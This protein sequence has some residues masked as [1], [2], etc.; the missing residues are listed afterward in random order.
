M[1]VAHLRELFLCLSTRITTRRNTH[2]EGTRVQVNIHVIAAKQLLGK[3]RSVITGLK[4]KWEFFISEAT[5]YSTN[6][7]GERSINE[8][9]Q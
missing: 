9:G 5:C 7:G 4:I 8:D 1:K 2:Y 3:I 6:G